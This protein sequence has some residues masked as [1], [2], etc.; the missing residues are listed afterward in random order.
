[1]GDTI[2]IPA[3]TAIVDSIT[4]PPKRWTA[5]WIVIRTDA[6]DT[7]LPPVG[8]RIDPSYVPSLASIENPAMYHY[9]NAALGGG[10]ALDNAH[11]YPGAYFWNY[12]ANNA[13][14]W[15]MNHCV[16]DTPYSVSSVSGKLNGVSYSGVYVVPG[17]NFAVG[18]IVF[19]SGINGCL[20]C[21][22]T[23]RVTAVS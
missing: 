11:C 17:N 5:G 13:P 14:A 1:Y 16:G 7:A 10:M 12:Q 2:K 20:K 3:N 8:V 21:N 22:G 6:P 19:V 18:E 15:L 4:L 9:M 23:G